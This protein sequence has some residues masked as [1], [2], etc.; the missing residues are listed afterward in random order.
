MPTP[1]HIRR[2]KPGTRVRP[3]R[4]RPDRNRDSANRCAAGAGTAERLDEKRLGE[5]LFAKEW[6]PDDPRSHGGDGLGPVYN[7]TSCVACH[8]LG[9]PGGA[10]P[11]SKNVVLMTANPGCGPT[12]L[13][14]ISPGFGGSRTAVLHHHGT[15]PEFASWRRQ[16]AS[17]DKKQPSKSA[18]DPIQARI[19]RDQPSER[20]RKI[21][22]V[23]DR[24]GLPR[25]R[26]LP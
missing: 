18:A 12:N 3:P 15:D 19:L 21:V 1:D 9:S 13:E 23:N 16:F 6:M 20:L 8:S 17:P 25:S 10:G 22:C 24:E 7:D 11:E 4:S 26:V 2:S 5:M 14:Q